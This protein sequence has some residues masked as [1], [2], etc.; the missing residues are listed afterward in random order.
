M[1]EDNKNFKLIF[2]MVLSAV[3]LLAIIGGLYYYY[4]REPSDGNSQTM[5]NNSIKA[6][7]SN[8]DSVSKKINSAPLAVLSLGDKDSDGD[9]LT[10][11]AEVKMGFDPYKNDFNTGEMDLDG[12]GLSDETEKKIGT[13]PNKK[14]TD[15]DG[16]SD[17][18]EITLGTNPLV[19]DNPLV[20]DPTL[21]SDSDGLTDV[22]EEKYGANKYH[23]DTDGDGYWDGEEVQNGYSPVGS[24]K[25]K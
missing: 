21:D 17:S 24:G 7:N 20:P 22:N 25:L 16:L 2:P 13:D 10:D 19:K 11:E 6:I 14:D 4:T 12:D 9:G 3:F 8:G 18:S 15:G 1:P 23:N 5:N